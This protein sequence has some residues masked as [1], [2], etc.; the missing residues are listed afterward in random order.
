MYMAGRNFSFLFNSCL[1]NE[2][3]C[4]PAGARINLVND[5]NFH[6]SGLFLS[7][8]SSLENV[9]IAKTFS[10]LVCNRIQKK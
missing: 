4:L 6:F 10:S 7:T 9:E 8:H 3:C 2:P 5:E 1:K